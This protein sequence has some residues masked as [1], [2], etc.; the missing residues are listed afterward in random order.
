MARHPLLP[1]ILTALEG[2]EPACRADPIDDYRDLAMLA[3]AWE[4]IGS[5]EVTVGDVGGNLHAGTAGSGA[6]ED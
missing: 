6:P 5:G 4:R 2:S 3:R 1:D